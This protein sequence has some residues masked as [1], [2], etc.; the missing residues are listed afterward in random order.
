[1]SRCIFQR[2]AQATRGP[3]PD[4]ALEKLDELFAKEYNEN[5][6]SE[7][8]NEP[9]DLTGKG[10]DAAQKVH[11]D[12]E[13]LLLETL[14]LNA[15]PSD[16]DN[17]LLTDLFGPADSASSGPSAPLMASEFASMFESNK[18]KPLVAGANDNA[19]LG[20]DDP[21][22]AFAAALPSRQ[23]GA[24]LQSDAASSGLLGH[25]TTLQTQWLSR[26]S[27]DLAPSSNAAAA[28]AAASPQRTAASNVKAPAGAPPTQAQGA[29]KKEELAAWFN[30]FADL[31][32]LAN[33]DKIGRT[34]GQDAFNEA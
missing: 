25:S 2:S 9:L 23:M 29:A 32:P 30:M 8:F 7:Q 13:S 21:W 11:K 31:D 4:I 15:A 10:N 1:M 18:P 17:A 14:D 22:N 33:P 6:D 16:S 28:A 34:P 3:N 5:E 12:P 24:L 27:A 20:D 26:A 19:L